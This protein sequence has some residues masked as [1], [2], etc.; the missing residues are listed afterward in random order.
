M[1]VTQIINEC[2]VICIVSYRVL[3]LKKA[4]RGLDGL[5]YDRQIASSRLGVRWSRIEG[6]NVVQR[7]P[8]LAGGL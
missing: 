5:Y 3:V 8:D 2:Y 4:Y 1:P 7:R 6:G